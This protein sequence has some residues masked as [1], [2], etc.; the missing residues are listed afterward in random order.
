MYVVLREI[1]EFQSSECV[2]CGV[3]ETLEMAK[4]L[5][6]KYEDICFIFDCD[7][8]KGCCMKCYVDDLGSIAFWKHR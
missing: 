4:E 6:D 2:L 1:G 8:N 7:L 5:T 3:F